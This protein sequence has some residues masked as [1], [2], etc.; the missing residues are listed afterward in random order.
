MGTVIAGYCII[1]ICFGA[2]PLLH[3][4]VSEVLP[5]KQRPM[6]QAS[7]N[8]TAGLGAFIAIVMGGSLLRHNVLENYRIYLYINAGIFFAATLGIAVCYNPPPLEMQISLTTSE[9]LRR[10]NWISYLLF[11]PGLVL[12]CVA[13]SW[14]RNPY[15][16]SSSRIIATFVVGA[17]FMVAFVGYE[18]L[19]TKH[20]ILDHGLFK[21]RNFA[22]ALLT[23]FSEGLSFF[24][25]NQYFAFDVT[26]A[27]GQDLLNSALPFGL[28]FLLSMMFALLGGYYSSKRKALKFPIAAGFL[29]IL[30]FFSCMSATYKSYSKA[31]FWGF[32]V[33]AGAGVGLI[34]PLIMVVAQLSTPAE[35]ISTASALVIATR[36]LGGTVGLAVN[37]AIFNSAL[38]TEIPKRI[39][40]ATLPLGLPPSSLGMLIG[41]LTAQDPALLAEVPGASPQIIGAAAGALKSA[42]GIGFRNCW[43]ASA[44][45]TAVALVG[46]STPLLSL[47]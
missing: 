1:G 31:H 20:G 37:N 3:A 13:L 16:W 9:K 23:I 14:S 15:P 27:T 32:A 29:M 44:C 41:A 21:N 40:A 17:V 25:I 10:L 8:A 35:L 47:Q 24:A 7:V 34:L 22:L 5:R 28:V 26:I 12:F 38:A 43:I 33:L 19:G 30:I 45:F 6:A 18:C 11:T 4:V 42:Y 39:A 36:S 2:Q 46:K